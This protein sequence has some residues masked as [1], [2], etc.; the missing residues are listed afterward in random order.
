MHEED[1]ARWLLTIGED[2]ILQQKLLQDA[3]GRIMT[4]VQR[5]FDMGIIDAAGN[6][7]QT[8]LPDDMQE[9]SKCQV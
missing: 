3:L 2:D 1:E 6:S 9:V 5:L 4:A 8:N 7:I